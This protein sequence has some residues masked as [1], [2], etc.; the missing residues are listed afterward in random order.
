MHPKP[1]AN[2]TRSTLDPFN[3]R[4]MPKIVA[5]TITEDEEAEAILQLLEARGLRLVRLTPEPEK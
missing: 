2:L 4:L 3:E 1:E 5:C